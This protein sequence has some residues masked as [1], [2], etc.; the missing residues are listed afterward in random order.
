[1]IS[2]QTSSDGAIIDNAA[3]DAVSAL[4]AR[5]KACGLNLGAAY[6]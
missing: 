6:A 2:L 5:T 4:L 1:M 3:L